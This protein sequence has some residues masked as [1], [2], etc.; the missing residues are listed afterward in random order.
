MN[1]FIAILNKNYCKRAKAYPKKNEP[2]TVKTFEIKD[3]FFV[4]LV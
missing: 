2:V 3:N 4:G 1:K